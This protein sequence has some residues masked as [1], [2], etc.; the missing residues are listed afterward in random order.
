LGSFEPASSH[1][2]ATARPYGDAGGGPRLLPRPDV[3]SRRNRARPSR[4]FS[5]TPTR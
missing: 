4:R 1:P 3:R 2:Q 5:L